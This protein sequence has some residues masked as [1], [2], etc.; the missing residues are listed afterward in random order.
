MFSTLI[1]FQTDRTL[2]GSSIRLH[3]STMIM[4]MVE[5]DSKDR[6]EYNTMWYVGSRTFKVLQ[7]LSGLG[8]RQ[9]Q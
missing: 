9:E 3:V 2:V 6:I 1:L 4:A 5:H 8:R 7:S